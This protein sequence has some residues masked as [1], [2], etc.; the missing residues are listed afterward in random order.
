MAWDSRWASH[1]LAGHSLTFC[2]LLIPCT[3]YS[4]NVVVRR[5]VSG[6]GSP[7]LHWKSCLAIGRYQSP[8]ARSQP[9]SPLQIPESFHCPRFLACPRDTPTPL[10]THR[11]TLIPVLSPSIF[12]TL[13]PSCSS[14]CPF[15]PSSLS[16]STPDVYF[17]FPFQC[18]L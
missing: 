11:H 7:P 9:G 15:Q 8:L 4:R 12:P 14:S 5:F 10:H 13:D 16:T 1:H 18:D 17:I 3:S 6:S 2:S